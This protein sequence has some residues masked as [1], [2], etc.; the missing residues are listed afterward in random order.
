MN[1]DE[2][3]AW[4]IKVLENPE[5]ND[6]KDNLDN[7]RHIII[8]LAKDI[9]VDV[10]QYRQYNKIFQFKIRAGILGQINKWTIPQIVE[11]KR[12]IDE[13]VRNKWVDKPDA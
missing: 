1:I 5:F 12:K 11:T 13:Y 10:L 6:K 8:F 9:L 3:Y 2:A 4:A 7:Y